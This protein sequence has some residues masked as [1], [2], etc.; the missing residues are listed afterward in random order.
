MAEN[1]NLRV[2]VFN[3]D[4]G[5]FEVGISGAVKTVVGSQAVGQIALKA[6]LTERGVFPVYGDYEDE[7]NNHVYGSDVKAVGICGEFPKD[8]RL[9]EI[10]RAAEEAIA[11]DPWIVSVDEVTVDEGTDRNGKPCFIVSVRF[12]DIFQNEV[13]VEGVEV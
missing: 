13:L 6:E 12:T 7:E 10:Q 11:Y 3:F 8:V 4:T 2:P 1:T 9:S 5:E